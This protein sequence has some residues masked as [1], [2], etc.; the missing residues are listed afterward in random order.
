M[1]QT[2]ISNFTYLSQVALFAGIAVLIFA[3]VE[4]KEQLEKIGHVLFILLG[5]LAAW[6]LASGQIVVPEI[7]DGQLP[8]EARLISFFT[9]LVVTAILAA[10]AIVLKI[11]KSKYSNWINVIIGLVALLLFFMVYELIKA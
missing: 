6:I 7:I 8:K 3:W 5:V 2:L 4:K 10:V 1:N 9:G 11:K